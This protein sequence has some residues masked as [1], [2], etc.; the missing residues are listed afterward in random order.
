MRIWIPNSITLGNLLMGCLAIVLSTSPITNHLELGM[1]CVVIAAIFDFFDGLV[2]RALKVSSDLG[3]Q[4]DS[5]ADVV[6]FGVVP[7]IW[8]SSLLPQDEWWRFI[9]F[10]MA[11]GAAYRLARFNL[12]TNA[13]EHFKGLPVPASAMIWVAIIGLHLNLVQTNGTGLSTTVLYSLSFIT[14]ALMVSTLPLLNLK[15]KGLVW[16]GQEVKWLLI[17]S[18][19]AVFTAVPLL[20]YS[21]FLAI[22]ISIAIYLI[23]SISHYKKFSS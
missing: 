5:L 21:M 4:L 23:L 3:A 2:A 14:T 1:T 22:L 20:G 6:S 17:L 16:K 15:F 12:D 10:I 8:A 9:P 19:I 18:I 13:M 7:A 11:L